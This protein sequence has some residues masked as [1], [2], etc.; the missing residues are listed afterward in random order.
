MQSVFFPVVVAVAVDIDD[1][2]CV[3]VAVVVVVELFVVE[4]TKLMVFLTC[5]EICGLYSAGSYEHK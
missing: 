1:D 2:V 3:V 4:S 5:V